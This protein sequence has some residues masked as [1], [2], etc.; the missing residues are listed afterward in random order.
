MTESDRTLRPSPVKALLILTAGLVPIVSAYEFVLV[1]L[2][3]YGYSLT[4]KSSM[5]VPFNAFLLLALV[6]SFNKAY[7]RTI[8]AGRLLRAE[9]WMALTLGGGALALYWA[10][11]MD[12]WLRLGPMGTE[13]AGFSLSPVAILGHLATFHEKGYWGWGYSW[14]YD[15]VT[16]TGT[17][18]TVYWILEAAILL[19]IPSGIVGRFLKNH[20]LCERCGA[21]M[22]WDKDIR[23][24]PESRVR[25]VEEGLRAGDFSPLEEPDRVQKGDPFTVR[26]DLMKCEVCPNVYYLH[27]YHDRKILLGKLPVPKEHLQKLFRP[28]RK[29]PAAGT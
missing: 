20:P 2:E 8:R 1:G 13:G 26:L 23:R 12:R 14:Y 24:L 25:K 9:A 21:W 17:T 22:T 10:W 16:V 11:A 15:R 19:L 29:K 5:M 4:E 18:L 28:L 6:A 7:L 3:T 27:L